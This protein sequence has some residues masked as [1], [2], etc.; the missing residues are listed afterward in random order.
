MKHGSLP[1]NLPVRSQAELEEETA[2]WLASDEAESGKSELIRLLSDAAVRFRL[3]RSFSP[4]ILRRLLAR[5]FSVP[6]TLWGGWAADAAKLRTSLERRLAASPG[7]I[8]SPVGV[9]DLLVHMLV[10]SVAANGFAYASEKEPAIVEA[11][12][13]R[14]V[15][16]GKVMPEDLPSLSFESAA[17]SHASGRIV[18]GL[19]TNKP[20]QERRSGL[21]PDSGAVLSGAVLS[22]AVPSGPVLPG[23]VLLG[24][25]LPAPVLSAVPSVPDSSDPAPPTAAS[26]RREEGASPAEREGIFIENAGLVLIAPFLPALFGRLGLAAKGAMVDCGSAMALLHYLATGVDDAAEFQLALPKALCGWDSRRPVDIPGGLPDEMK[27]EAGL[28]L[29]SV[30]EHWPALKNTSAEGFRESFLARAGKLT[31]AKDEWLLQVEQKAFDML[32]K[33]VPWTISPLRL[34]WMK[35]PLFTDWVG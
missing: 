33:Q 20:P 21:P 10:E 11:Y 14:L 12:L 9:P 13:S 29:D 15:L 28:L 19:R 16:E 3:R 7:E 18:E 2:A 22:G 31:F 4:P 5:F 1:W 32:I 35:H 8:P 6:E 30:I 26:S 27:A 23:P 17:F 24:P 25:V 34:P